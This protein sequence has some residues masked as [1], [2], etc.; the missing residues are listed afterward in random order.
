MNSTDKGKLSRTAE[1]HS[2]GIEQLADSVLR[3]SALKMEYSASN[4]IQFSKLLN[5]AGRTRSRTSKTPSPT[6][7]YSTRPLK[8][9][10]IFN[11]LR[12]KEEETRC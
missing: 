10:Y 2:D 11:V 5:T 3:F 1:M 7:F 6:T 9:V 4:F 12:T 8:S